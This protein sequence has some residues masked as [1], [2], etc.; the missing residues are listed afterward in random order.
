MQG[1]KNVNVNFD[2]SGI[3]PTCMYEFNTAIRPADF[4]KRRKYNNLCKNIGKALANNDPSFTLTCEDLSLYL[5]HIKGK[6]DNEKKRYCKYFFHKLNNELKD[7]S[8]S[9]VGEKKCYDQIIS[10]EQSD[11]NNLFK[12]CHGEYNDFDEKIYTI[13]DYLDKLYTELKWFS[14]DIYKCL[15]DSDPFNE[16]MKFLRDFH[17]NIT[18][19][20]V[21]DEANEKYNNYR[22]KLRDCSVAANLIYYSS[23]TV[24]I[25][26]VLTFSIIIFILILYKYTSYS[27]YIQQILSNLKHLWNNR[28]EEQHELYNLFDR[29]YKNLTY[30]SYRIL[31]NTAQY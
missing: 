2:F 9:C 28:S 4:E 6:G 14:Y 20:S 16:Y 17:N 30:N 22:R 27:P 15:S 23:W 10:T 11:N 29:E 24:G 31:Y 3:F 8:Y 7:Q 21:L 12:I 5:E 19:Q 13:F 1:T 25:L 18:L 26:F